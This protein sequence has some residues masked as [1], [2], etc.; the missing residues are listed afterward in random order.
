MADLN[1]TPAIPDALTITSRNARDGR[2]RTWSN[3]RQIANNRHRR[4]SA[5]ESL[6]P[7]HAVSL[8][9]L[10][11]TSGPSFRIEQSGKRRSSKNVLALDDDITPSLGPGDRVVEQATLMFSITAN[12]I[13]PNDHDALE[14]PVLSLLYRHRC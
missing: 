4:G 3:R 8:F 9:P 1:P 13:G 12:L 2:L 5:V 10:F 14:L 6:G 11:L 7:N